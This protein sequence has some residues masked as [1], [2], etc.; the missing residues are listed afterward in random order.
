MATGDGDGD[1]FSIPSCPFQ[2]YA[3]M[4]HRER[5]ICM[6]R[7][8]NSAFCLVWSLCRRASDVRDVIIILKAV[9]HITGGRHLSIG[10]VEAR[11]ACHIQKHEFALSRAN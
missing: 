8:C 3:D 7:F 2:L 9:Q 1:S 10:T 5:S 4:G 11:L 6:R